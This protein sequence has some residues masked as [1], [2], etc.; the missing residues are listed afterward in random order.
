M[1][2]TGFLIIAI[3]CLFLS[4]R[5]SFA[6]DIRTC[7][8]Q[9]AVRDYIEANT[10]WPQG[11]VRVNFLSNEPE[12][13]PQGRPITMRVETAGNAD[14]IGDMVFLVKF[15]KG[16]NFFKT[17]TVRTRIEILHDIVIATRTLPSGTVLT[18]GDIKT[19]RKWVHKIQPQTI[20]SPDRAVGRR[21]IVQAR[22]GMEI[23]ANMLRDVPLVQKGK[24]V[25]IVF[26][27]G[28]M[29]I[30]TVGM[31]EEDGVAGSIIRVKNITSN[32]II[33]ARVLGTSLVGIEI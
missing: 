21:I 29:R 31:P 28:T 16:G 7:R 5:D 20:S 17:E 14:F 27:S 8:L 9:D 26:D 11:T 2:R 1:K 13:V 6:T 24:I 32:K 4:A 19:V 30:V 22:P 33:Y 3:L 18:D 12:T 25:K 23:Y 10:P 15:F